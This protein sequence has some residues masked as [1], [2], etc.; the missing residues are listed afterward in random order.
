MCR[1]VAICKWSNFQTKEVDKIKTTNSSDFKTTALE[2]N[3]CGELPSVQI[4]FRKYFA[5]KLSPKS[6]AVY[7]RINFKDKE[8]L[9]I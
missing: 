3:F 1:K 8:T 9:K 2:K 6:R 7:S 4:F 5:E